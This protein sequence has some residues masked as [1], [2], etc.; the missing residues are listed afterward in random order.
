M[1]ERGPCDRVRPSQL[2]PTDL[3][4]RCLVCNGQQWQLRTT[5]WVRAQP[6]LGGVAEGV[7]A[8][9]ESDGSDV[10]ECAACGKLYWEGRHIDSAI[11]AFF[12]SL[13]SPH[14]QPL[15]AQALG[16]R[17]VR[18]APSSVSGDSE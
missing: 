3:F 13:L 6:G 15:N 10:Y 11:Q 12:G 9:L 1:G 8:R 5:V 4:S 18:G 14:A 17:V 2:Q 7:L 16:R